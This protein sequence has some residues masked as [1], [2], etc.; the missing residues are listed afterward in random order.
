MKTM[1]KKVSRRELFKLG[2]LLPALPGLVKKSLEEQAEPE[3]EFDSSA[4]KVNAVERCHP[5]K[6][7][8]ASSTMRPEWLSSG[9]AMVVPGRWMNHDTGANE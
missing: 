6:W 1:A 9:S 5:Y 4:C 7:A 2:G 8:T 3:Q